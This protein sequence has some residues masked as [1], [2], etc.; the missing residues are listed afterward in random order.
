MVARH[1]DQ[2]QGV[3]Q[4][5]NAEEAADLKDPSYAI[6]HLDRLLLASREDE[7]PLAPLQEGPGAQAEIHERLLA[8]RRQAAL[9]AAHAEAADRTHEYRD[10]VV[11]RPRLVGDEPQND[12]EGSREAE[13][14]AA[15]AQSAQVVPAGCPVGFA[16][17]TMW[18]VAIT[19]VSMKEPELR[20]IHAYKVSEGRH[21]LE[22][23]E[24]HHHDDDKVEQLLGA[25]VC[26]ATQ[27]SRRALDQLERVRLFSRLAG[28]VE[29]QHRSAA[30]QDEEPSAQ[31]GDDRDHSKG[32]CLNDAI[33]GGLEAIH[34]QLYGVAPVASTAQEGPSNHDEAQA[35]RE[36]EVGPPLRQ[37]EDVAVATGLPALQVVRPSGQR[38]SREKREH[39][40]HEAACAL[41]KKYNVQ[42]ECQDG[43][44]AAS[45]E[46]QP[47]VL[48]RA[49]PDDVFR[50]TMLL[51][52]VL[53]ERSQALVGRHAYHS[54]EFC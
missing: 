11:R 44:K 16:E 4:E 40:P 34:S 38:H 14:K 7:G 43:Q 17:R 32:P 30:D 12:A 51:E 1:D 13:Q 18:H 37:A 54:H 8:E 47:S 42:Q 15:K 27:Q 50:A 46:G 19:F 45:T 22:V 26:M 23:P 52:P 36:L 33:A 48:K 3:G 24:E 39:R 5:A 21:E 25:Q 10:W 6:E 2:S 41:R 29:Q 49:Q 53:Q 9:E 28:R 31:E 20:Q 35:Q